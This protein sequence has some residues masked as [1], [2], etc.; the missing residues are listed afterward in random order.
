MKVLVNGGTTLGL[1]AGGL[2]PT[3]PKWV[4]FG[5]GPEHGDDPA[6]DPVEADALYEL[7]EQQVIPEF[8]DRDPSGIPVLVGHR[9]RE[10]MAG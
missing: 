7:L 9:M 5:D 1:T 2:R 10:S 8:Y 4:G 6:W 3:R